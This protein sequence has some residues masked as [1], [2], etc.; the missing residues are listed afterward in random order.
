[1]TNSPLFSNA[2]PIA[3]STK[4]Q[5][6]TTSQRDRLLDD[7]L[8]S[9]A[10]R[11]GAVQGSTHANQTRAWNRWQSYCKSVGLDDDIFLTSFTKQQQAKIIGAFASALREGPYLRGNATSLATSTV[12]NTINYVVATFRSEG[13]S[14]P[15]R[16]EDGQLA[17]ILS[18]HYCA[19]KN[20]DPKENQEKAIPACII[21][22]I[23]LN[24][25]TE[26]KRSPN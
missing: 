13:R 8:A 24:Q 10:A 5:D 18:R 6:S 25:T 11:K 2:P 19:Y 1:M 23:N 7:L 14:N 16:N 3:G 15:T 21:S 20:S 22:Q 4:L 12:K 26:T 9:E 17:W